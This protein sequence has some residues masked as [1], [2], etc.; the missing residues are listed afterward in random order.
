M[1]TRL[2]LP[3]IIFIATYADLFAGDAL[4]PVEI[5]GALMVEGNRIVDR[6]GKPVQLRGMSFFWS[7]WMEKYY[8]DRVVKWL[9]NDWKVTVVRAAMGVKHEDSETGYLFGGSD[10]YKVEEI[11]KAAIK[12]GI[13]VIID[14]HDYYAHEHTRSAKR[15]FEMMSKKYGGYPNVIYE[16][17]NEPVKADWSEEVKPYAEEVIAEIRALD[18]DNLIVIGSPHWCQDVDEP[19][20]DPIDGRNLAYSLH[21]YAATHGEALRD[22]AQ[23][24]LEKGLAL[25]ATEFGTCLASGDG[26]LDSVSTMQWFEF[27]DKHAISWCNWSIADKEET[28]S[29]LIPGARWNGSWSHDELTSSGRIIRRKLRQDAGYE[30]DTP[31][32][33]KKEKKKSRFKITPLW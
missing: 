2:I 1:C 27:L 31:P 12:Y 24:A 17:Y 32:P 8:N 10:K 11:V 5:H 15:F 26:F 9:V 25:F 6:K 14:W 21:F 20:K 22:K 28:S 30:D 3:V 18:S 7:Q 23:F 29:A 13:Y 33:R 19:A 16:I 4:T